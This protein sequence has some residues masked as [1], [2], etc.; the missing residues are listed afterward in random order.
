MKNGKD[1][2]FSLRKKMACFGNK[3]TGYIMEIGTVKFYV[4][5]IVYSW[6]F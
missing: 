3:Q 6:N 2:V 1:L 5:G 4:H